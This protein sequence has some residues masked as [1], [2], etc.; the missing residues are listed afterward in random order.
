MGRQCPVEENVLNFELHWASADEEAVDRGTGA[1]TTDDRTSA[2]K[3]LAAVSA[4][5]MIC[6]EM[7]DIPNGEE[8][9]QALDFLVGQW[10]NF[11]QDKWRA[12]PLEGAQ[13]MPTSHEGTPQPEQASSRGVIDDE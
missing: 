13:A 1:T 9:N 2:Q 5:R 6:S 7:A 3:Y 10:R 11:R 4:T 12:L 8:V